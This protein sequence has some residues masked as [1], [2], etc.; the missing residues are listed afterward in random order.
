MKHHITH[1]HTHM[2]HT[3]TQTYLVG[4]GH[5]AVECLGDG[6]SHG[7]H[8]GDT[9]LQ[10]HGSHVVR[11]GDEL[12]AQIL[13]R[14]GED[15]TA[16]HETIFEHRLDLESV[17]E[18]LDVHLG[19]QSHVRGSHLVARRKQSDRAHDLCVVYIQERERG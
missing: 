19:E 16:I 18:R 8:G 2:T 14:E 17:E 13:L 4:D 12:V 5:H 9:E 1:R 7:R 6:V 11:T 15:L 10:T 3:H